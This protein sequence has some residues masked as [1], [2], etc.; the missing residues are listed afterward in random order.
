[1]C[2]LNIQNTDVKTTLNFSLCLLEDNEVYYCQ[3][4][5]LVLILVD[6][7]KNKDCKQVTLG[8]DN[9]W[10]LGWRSIKWLECLMRISE[11][12]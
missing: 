9:S 1:M 11:I 10:I 4:Y 5:L 6:L 8:L 3:Y 2:Y 12:K 7:S